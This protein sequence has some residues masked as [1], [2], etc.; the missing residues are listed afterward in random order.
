MLSLLLLLLL[1]LVPF[2]SFRPNG[3]GPE[4]E[5]DRIGNR[6]GWNRMGFGDAAAPVEPV[7]VLR[8]V[9]PFLRVFCDGCVQ[10]GYRVLQL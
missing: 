3:M 7:L 5:S 2:L 6:I 9:L 10:A 4:T 8:V 1:L